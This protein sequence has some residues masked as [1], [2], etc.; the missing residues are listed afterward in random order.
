MMPKEGGVRGGGGE[1]R[2]LRLAANRE[3]GGHG[4]NEDLMRKNIP[5]NFKETEFESIA[6]LGADAE[7]W[8]DEKAGICRGWVRVR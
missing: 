1:G 4:V 3:Y 7:I 8:K 2:D 5:D 6:A